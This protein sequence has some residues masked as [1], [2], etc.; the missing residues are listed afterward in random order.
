MHIQEAII[1]L[2]KLGE[3]LYKEGMIYMV[4]QNIEKD[5]RETE[6]FKSKENG[7]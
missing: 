7:K 3:D 5:K 1:T 6:K 2:A 4:L